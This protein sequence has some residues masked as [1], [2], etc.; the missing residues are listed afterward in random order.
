MRFR[1][2]QQSISPHPVFNEFMQEM[3]DSKI[4]YLFEDKKG[5]LWVGMH[6]KGLCVIHT[7]SNGFTNYR[8]INNEPNSLSYNHV[9]GVTAD[10]DN[11]LWI[12]TDGGGLN[13]Y[14]RKSGRFTHY[15][16]N[17]GNPNVDFGQCH[18]ECFL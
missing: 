2:D 18:R 6:Y 9:M 16:H 17:P 15:L 11:N 14:D 3:G 12:A 8:K 7:G 1:A 10:K 5:N 4:H 13:F